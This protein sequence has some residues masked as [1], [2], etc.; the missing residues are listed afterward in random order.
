MNVT[1]KPGFPQD[2]EKS[3][4]WGCC[5]NFPCDCTANL[6]IF[7][8]HQYVHNEE[9]AN[10][11]NGSAC[12]YPLERTPVLA[13]TVIGTIYYD[14]VPLC[15]FHDNDDGTFLLSWLKATEQHP[16]KKFPK[17]VSGEINYTTGI[18]TLTW[19][20]EIS[21]GSSLLVIC[22][23]YNL[24]CQ[25]APPKKVSCPNCKHEFYDIPDDAISLQQLAEGDGF[26]DL[27]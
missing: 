17:L 11:G 12:K 8:P 7:Y 23:E 5:G 27:Y 24:E 16:D 18:V 4:Q 25:Q 2:D 14:K 22:Y 21:A 15:T 6:D 26:L 20:E 19:G 3:L 13:K 1:G 9:C 10:Y